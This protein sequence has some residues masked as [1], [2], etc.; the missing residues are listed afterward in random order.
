MN[1]AQACNEPE[2]GGIRCSE[3][4]RSLRS[5]ASMAIGMKMP[6]APIFFITADRNVTAEV[7]ASTWGR[8]ASE[9]TGDAAQAGR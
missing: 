8:G 6:R 3:G 4:G 7:S 2:V 9:H 1:I 5:A